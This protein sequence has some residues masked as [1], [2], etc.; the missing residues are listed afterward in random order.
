MKKKIIW[1]LYLCLLVCLPLPACLPVACL[2]WYLV[3]VVVAVGCPSIRSP[4]NVL[5]KRNGSRVQPSSCTLNHT[6]L[7]NCRILTPTHAKFLALLHEANQQPVQ[8][9]MQQHNPRGAASVMHVPPILLIIQQCGCTY[10]VHA[11]MARL[12]W[13]V[14]IH[15]IHRSGIVPQ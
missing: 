9:G 12:P 3:F 1:R 6:F 4:P 8:I 13:T 7:P 11:R 5:H 15:K 10:T 14:Y 2:A